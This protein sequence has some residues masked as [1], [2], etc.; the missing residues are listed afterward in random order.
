MYFVSTRCSGQQ[1]A[2]QFSNYRVAVMV[3]TS[4]AI[5][6]FEAEVTEWYRG[7]LVPWG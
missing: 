6:P 5:L 1:L 7:P 3:C 2:T 4:Q